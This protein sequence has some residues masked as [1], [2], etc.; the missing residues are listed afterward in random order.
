M[1]SVR[2]PFATPTERLATYFDVTQPRA[3]FED[4]DID[5]IAILLEQCG[6]VAS[7]CPR[8]YILFRT[9]GHLE[10]IEQLVKVGFTDQWFPVAEARSLPSFLEPSIKAAVVQQQE[11]ILSKSLDLEN[12][13]HSHFRPQECLPFEILGRLGSGSYGQVDRILSKTSFRQFALKRI[14]RRV[15]FGNTSSRE[16]LQ[17]FLDEMIIIKSLK[18][19]HIVEYIGSYTDKSYLGLVMSPVA[20][21]DLAAYNERLC[22]L[23]RAVH[24]EHSSSPYLMRDQRTADE[25]S[26]NLRTF[27]GCLTAALTVSILY[28]L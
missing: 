8:T 13:K 22:G 4:R 5:E 10:S 14:R 24:T 27:F 15:V 7:K 18:H 26:S 21:T 17:G 12:G 16:A 19:H 6:H 20:D 25:M 2:S 11:I 1:T 23:L 9:I 3:T 28:V